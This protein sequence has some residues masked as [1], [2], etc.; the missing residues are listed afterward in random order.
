LKRRRKKAESVIADLMRHGVGRLAGSLQKLLGFLDPRRLD[1]VQ[2]RVW[3][4]GLIVR[5]ADTADM[6]A[7]M[8]FARDHRLLIQSFGGFGG[9]SQTEKCQKESETAV[10]IQP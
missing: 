4:A 6:L 1:I 5:C 7:C 8:R 3:R 10:P 2:R 9:K